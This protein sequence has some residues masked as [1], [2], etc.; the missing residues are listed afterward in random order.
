MK[1][2]KNMICLIVACVGVVSM[3]FL[4]LLS[5]SMFGQS[6][7]FN[8]FDLISE[9]GLFDSFTSIAW[10]LAIIAGAGAAFFAFK[11][12][13]NITFLASVV[14]AGLLLLSLIFAPEGMGGFFGMGF[15]IALIAFVATAVMTKVFANEWDAE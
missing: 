8:F 15:W 13:K 3:L 11:K 1:L 7:S 14:A 6:M 10:L 9:G 12:D 4:P 2:T 5:I